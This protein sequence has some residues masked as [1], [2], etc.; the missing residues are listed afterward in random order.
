MIKRLNIFLFCLLAFS[1]C[2]VK[3]PVIEET[4]FFYI[5]PEADITSI[6][7]LVILEFDN[8][9]YYNTIEN[10]LTKQV[11]T[12]LV[13]KH[14]FEISYLDSGDILWPQVHGIC[15]KHLDKQQL[16]RY[17]EILQADAVLTGE[18]TEYKPFP[19]P[20]IGLKA[21]MIDLRTG[22]LVWSLEQVWDSVDIG[23]ENRIKRYY[24]TTVKTG[25]EPMGWEY[26]RTSPS[27]YRQFVSFEIASTLPSN[28]H[29]KKEYLEYKNKPN[30]FKDG[31]LRP[32]V[33]FPKTARETIGKIR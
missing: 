13:K 27:A 21:K 19:S 16:D 7:K 29:Y 23:V 6:K 1:G 8:K 11:Y 30:N 12:T 24:D 10:M 14:L 5:N 18:I 25:Y 20:L 3:Q 33:R 31:M 28:N 4:G 15:N 17:C 32:V 9:T 26:V 22:Q 2:S